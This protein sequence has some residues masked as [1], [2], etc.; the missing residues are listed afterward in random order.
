MTIKNNKEL[1]KD[2]KI[3]MLKNNFNKMQ[4]SK[5]LNVS[6]PTIIKQVNEPHSMT[7]NQ[8][9]RMCVVLKVSVKELLIKN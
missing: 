5:K 8:F 7:L 9:K 6:Y 2:I 4:L 3:E 1:S